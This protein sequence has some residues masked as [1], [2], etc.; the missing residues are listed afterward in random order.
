MKQ[1]LYLLSLFLIFTS[2]AATQTNEKPAD[3]P[4]I[5]IHNSDNPSPGYLLLNSFNQSPFAAKYIIVVDSAGEPI[6]HKKTLS[7]SLDFK[8]QPNGLYSYAQAIAL[9]EAHNIA[10]R[11]VRNAKTINYILDQDFNLV[12]SVQCQN[13][14]LSDPHEFLILPNGNYLMIAYESVPVDMSLVVPGGEPNAVVVGTVIQEL[15]RNKKCV[16]QWRSL[17]NLPLT[18]TFANVRGA[19]FEHVHGNSYYL[20]TDGNLIVSFTASFDIVKIDLINGDIKWHFGGKRNN[21]EITGDDLF[22]PLHF[23]NQHDIKRLDNGNFFFFDNGFAKNPPFS[24]AVE[25]SVNEEEK[26][27]ELVWEYRRTPDISAFAMG[28][29]Q[30]LK[31]GNT[32]INWGMIFEG[33]HRA[34]T[35][36]T[37]N[38]DIVYEISLPAETFSYRAFKY[39]YPLCQPVANVTIPEAV[40]GNRYVF[41]KNG[42][43]TGAV[44]SITELDAFMYNYLTFKK[45]DCSPLNPEFET[46]A[47][48]ILPNR[49]HFSTRFVYSIK[50]ELSF[51]ISQLPTRYAYLKLQENNGLKVYHRKTE[52]SGMFIELPTY[53][54]FDPNNHKLIAMISDTGE[55][56]IGYQRSTKYKH[57]NPPALMHPKNE[58]ILLT[59]KPLKFTWSP[60]GRYDKYSIQISSDEN[61]NEIISSFDNIMNTT[62]AIELNDNN[63][64]YWRVK[65]YYNDLESN[66]SQPWEFTLTD[67]FLMVSYPTDNTILYTD[68]TAIIRWKTNISDSLKIELYKSNVQ[69]LV[70]KDSLFSYTN[71]YAWKLPKSLEQGNDYSMVITSIKNNDISTESF[72]FS[73]LDGA[74]GIEQQTLSSQFYIIPNPASDFIEITNGYGQPRFF[75]IM[76]FEVLHHQQSIFL[77]GE[78]TRINTSSLKPG[79]YIIQIGDTVQKFIKY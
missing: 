62:L 10:G 61:F 59:G 55:Y 45:F 68:S 35:E 36:V 42:I 11:I 57:I 27:A 32:L 76:G 21:F 52:G 33:D 6:K 63:K 73:I 15:D 31:N 2:Y 16:F 26:T 22:K 29:A 3:F 37:P 44:L 28:S 65:T 66:W 72:P 7:A 77:H 78:K 4:K 75:N 70:I 53:F 51:D 46:E 25:F 9:G 58:A 34:V 71:A 74:T 39:E 14:Y 49:Y 50:G 17:D 19:S 23:S 48:V 54:E 20:D 18:H 12:D 67:T 40:Q 47:P 5:T 24:R 30:R 69:V 79:V 13:G 38:K 43:N 8:L 56:I 64:Y 1:Y 60:S 41:E